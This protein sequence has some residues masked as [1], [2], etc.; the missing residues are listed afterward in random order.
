M[1][2]HTPGAGWELCSLSSEILESARTRP[3]DWE[4]TTLD[5]TWRQI[6]IRYS[7][8]EWCRLSH[9]AI[10]GLRNGTKMGPL[11]GMLEQ[12]AQTL[13]PSGS[14][15]HVSMRH[16]GPLG[17][18]RYTTGHCLPSWFIPYMPTSVASLFGRSWVERTTLS[19]VVYGP[20]P[21]P[22]TLAAQT[23]DHWM[24]NIGWLETSSGQPSPSGR[25]SGEGGS[26]SGD[27]RQRTTTDIG[28][29][30]SEVLGDHCLITTVMS[31]SDEASPSL[32]TWLGLDECQLL[33]DRWQ[34]PRQ[35]PSP[36]PG[37][38]RDP[39]DGEIIVPAEEV[40][41]TPV[42][43]NT[44][45]VV[46]EVSEAPNPSGETPPTDEV[47]EAGGDDS[48]SE[49]V[50]PLDFPLHGGNTPED[51][52]VLAATQNGR[53]VLIE[54]SWGIIG[55]D[56]DR[57]VPK[58]HA[59]IMGAVIAPIPKLPH[60]YSDTA[61]NVEAAKTERLDK[62]ARQPEID[63]DLRT[64]IGQVVKASI[65]G[66]SSLAWCS[67]AKV[68]KW[69]ENNFDLSLIKS[70]KW[71][72]ERF[73]GAV[74]NLLT[75]ANPEMEFKLAVK[76]EPMPYT[77]A[78]R[79]LIADGDSGQLMGLAVV[80]CFEDLLFEQFESQ[81]IKHCAKRDAIKRIVGQLIRPGARIIEGD[82][83]AWDTTCNQE[84]RDLVENPLLHHICKVL[85]NYGVVPPQWLLAYDAANWAKTIKGVYRKHRKS[86]TLVFAAIRR[87]GDRKT[88]CANYWLN[89][90]CMSVAL[91]KNPEEFLDP[92]RRNAVAVDGS[93][94]WCYFA[95][96]GDD[97]IVSLKPPMEKGSALAKKFVTSWERCGFNME[98]VY[99]TTRATFVGYHIACRD[100]EA[101]DCY[102]PEL[103]RA[104]ANA[105][106]STSAAAVKAVKAGDTETLKRLASAACI[107]R[108]ADFAGIFPSVS[109]KF[110]QY[111]LSCDS[112][113]F[114]D[115]EMSFRA[116]DNPGVGSHEIVDRIRTQNGPV[117]QA[118]EDRALVALG[119][120]VTEEERT[121][122]LTYTWDWT[123]LGDV[124]GF[125]ESIPSAWR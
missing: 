63:K 52:E 8:K 122:F 87:S 69:A 83:S 101:I 73:E 112:A 36:S 115:R 77:K 79:M 124:D 51:T 81:S 67:E 49:Y 75:R 26:T 7:E 62:K 59:P 22:R 27:G 78:P 11:H 61:E 43:D 16:L 103:P 57:T 25:S 12:A 70:G 56:F 6:E 48:A 114:Q 93:R 23:W 96:E 94:R 55:Q 74:K 10:H 123:C 37:S 125:C 97:S 95:F 38:S 33:P 41:P 50:V 88:S 107:A 104:L 46:A 47:V 71:S 109:E 68:Q 53:T 89:R 45:E 110:L 30:F 31:P 76:A 18:L 15:E 40:E 111:A 58:D 113:N 117:T 54:D 65:K 24:D 20:K 13:W 39:D 120:G 64:R 14:L 17:V 91:F 86:L 72:H 118:D 90:V 100:G 3:G 4:V 19:R 44:G 2:A 116:A 34:T 35:A 28:S 102:S 29:V 121:R 84:I 1:L 21:D 92:T 119:Y 80:R 42:V 105:G 82:G 108:A 32:T 106:V 98:I 5:E 85:L 99:C 66:K 60:V 9:M